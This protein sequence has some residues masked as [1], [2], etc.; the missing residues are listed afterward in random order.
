VGGLSGSGGDSWSVSP[1]P[2]DGRKVGNAE[3]ICG[4]GV[5]VGDALEAYVGIA[6]GVAL[7]DALAAE[8]GDA[9]GAK[10]GDA[11]GAKVG[12]DR[13]W[14]L[15][16]PSQPGNGDDEPGAASPLARH[17]SQF[18]L[19]PYAVPITLIPAAPEAYEDPPPEGT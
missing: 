10:V 4:M 14:M 8:V 7:G 12:G 13:H 3:E 6:L 17:S 16:Y 9:L 19:L 1:D 2:R 18:G 15:T 11:L 5:E